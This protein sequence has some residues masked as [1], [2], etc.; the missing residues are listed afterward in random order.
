MLTDKGEVSIVHCKDKVMFSANEDSIDR[1]E[2][3]SVLADIRFPDS[4][5]L[6]K[7]IPEYNI[8]INTTEL[9]D[10]LKRLKLYTLEIPRVEMDMATDELVVT[11][12]DDMTGKSGEESMS[13]KNVTSKP[14]RKSFNADY[15]V[16]VL[17]EID[18][19]NFTFYYGTEEKKPSFI[20]P[21][22]EGETKDTG[23]IFLV[24]PMLDK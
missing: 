19:N 4:E 10:A 11:A 18:E 9:S 5:A 21:L 22:K 3:L 24:S 6:L 20:I 1:F 16:D 12:T 8:V 17:R 14:L 2:V 7:K 13:V 23:L 15:I